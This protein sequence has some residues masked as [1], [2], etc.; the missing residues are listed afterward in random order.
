VDALHAPIGLDIGAETP[1]ELAVSILAELVAVRRKAPA[2][3]SM[4]LARAA[5]T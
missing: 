1:E 2:P 3:P 4:R 5:R